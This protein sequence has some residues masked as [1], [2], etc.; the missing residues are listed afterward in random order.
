MKLI[1]AADDKQMAQGSLFWDD[2]ETIGECS[3]DECN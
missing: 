1:V 2:G 3:I